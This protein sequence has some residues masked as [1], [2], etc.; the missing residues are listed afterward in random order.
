VIAW[1]LGASGT[2]GHVVARELLSRGYDVVAL[3]R[4]DAPDLA[5]EAK[6]LGRRWSFAKLDLTAA[7][8]VATGAMAEK[9]L[10]AAGAGIPDVLVV[11]SAVTG[12]DRERTMRANCLIPASLVERAAAVM[13]DHGSGRIG[14]FLAQNARLGLAGLGDYSAAQAALWTWCEAFQGDLRARHSPVT[15][16]R[17]IP[18]RAASATQ[19][20]VTEHSGHEARL[21]EPRADK[22][23]SAILA[24]KRRCGRRPV[25]AALSTL[26][27]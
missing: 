18:P 8:R 20:W 12:R 21:H 25:L 16:T 27:R 15:V 19:R 9:A 14:V 22:I 13:T 1:V 3:G 11:C 17:V 2:W 10:K 6:R 5:G 24:G 26:L 23:V 4:H 7:E